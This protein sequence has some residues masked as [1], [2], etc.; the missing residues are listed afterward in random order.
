MNA[1]KRAYTKRWC[2]LNPGVPELNY[3]RTFEWIEHPTNTEADFLDYL[4]ENDYLASM[5]WNLATKERNLQQAYD[6]LLNKTKLLL[7]QQ[8]EGR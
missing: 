4:H 7:A 1:A 3:L 6:N 5:R 8:K 2:S